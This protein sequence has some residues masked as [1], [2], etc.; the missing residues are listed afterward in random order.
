MFKTKYLLVM[1]ATFATAASSQPLTIANFGGAAGKA[2]E[3][4]FIKPFSELKK[5][6]AR[7]VEYPGDLPA[8]HV[9]L[10]KRFTERRH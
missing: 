10:E 5:L 1:T 3:I 7:G 4:A 2:Q 9:M 8:V 6:E